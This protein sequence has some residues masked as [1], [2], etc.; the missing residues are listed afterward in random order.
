MP[1]ASGYTKTSRFA[2]VVAF[3]DALMKLPH[4]QRLRRLSCGKTTEGR[5]L[6]LVIVSEPPLADDD[7]VMKSGKLR[8]LVSANIHAGEVEGKEAA[9][10]LLR[11]LANGEH[12][13]LLEHAVLLFMPIYNADGNDKISTRNRRGQNGPVGGVG[14]RPN[15][16]GLDLNRDFIKVAAPETKAMHGVWNRYD[17]HVFMDLHTTNGS[18]HG[19]HLTYSPSLS[20]NVDAGLRSF[21]RETFLKGIRAATKA[22]HGF[23]IY[24]YGNFDRR[25]T[26]W[27]TY[28]H[29]ARYASNC[30][31]LRNR[32]G[33]LSEAFSY[34]AFEQRIKVTRA[35]VLETLRAA[36]RHHD[37]IRELCA[38]ADERM[39][40]EGVRFGYDT[41]LEKPWED[42]ILVGSVTR[43]R[44]EG[45]TYRN[46]ASDEYEARKM[47]VQVAF[48]AKQS[49]VLPEAW[50][51]QGPSQR[52]LTALQAQGVRFQKL[53]EPRQVMAEVF[54]PTEVRK[55]RRV[56]QKSYQVRIAGKYEKQEVELPAGTVWVPGQQRLARLAA[57][58]LEAVSE[59]SLATWNYFDEQLQKK[60]DG[61]YGRYPVVRVLAVK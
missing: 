15:A 2:D 61:S 1:E 43:E 7:A 10:I 23:R 52:V 20:A 42:T 5:E 33:V 18:A 32:I 46:I 40:K 31:G 50:A 4:A 60:A 19:Y 57:Q 51:I 22:R 38:A 30:F 17:P 39:L 53:K 16:E 3:L 41:E 36:V 25:R 11:E 14:R 47:Q 44:V 35:F 48:V 56:F 49:V 26:T 29:R 6:P 8:L 27:R 28:D 54:L 34:I 37:R 45:G 21:I 13:D 58:D 9:Q 55:S 24:D 12:E 59:D